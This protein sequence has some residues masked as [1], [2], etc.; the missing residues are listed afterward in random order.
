MHA[1]LACES[2]SKDVFVWRNDF[3]T[4]KSFFEKSYVEWE[5][6]LAWFNKKLSDPSSKMII[7]E[8]DKE[9]VGIVRYDRD[10]SKFLVSINTNPN[11]RGKGYSS[12]MLLESEYFLCK[13]KKP[14]HLNAEILNENLLSKKTFL[15]AGYEFSHEK[16]EYSCFIKELS[17]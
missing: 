9:K 11:H 12:Q 13:E 7:I 6:H 2:D 3:I 14:V 1:R 10:N 4:R 17:L 15:K 5:T 8:V 16:K